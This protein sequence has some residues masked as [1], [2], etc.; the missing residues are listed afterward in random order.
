SHTRPGIVLFDELEK[1]SDE[2]ILAL[3]NVLDN[4]I[5]TVASGERTYSFRNSLIFMSSNL[6][7][8]ELQALADRGAVARAGPGQRLRH[9]V[10][11]AVTPRGDRRE[12]ATK[13][14]T[15]S[16]LKRFP[17][18]FV[19]RIDHIEAFDWIGAGD[20]PKLVAVELERLNRRL[21]KHGFTVELDPDT[22]DFIAERGFDPRF[23]ARGMR[24]AMRQH[25]EFPLAEYLLGL[26]PDSGTG[27]DV[28]GTRVLRAGRDGQR[29]TFRPA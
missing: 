9:A 2:V 18:E 19:N 17:P 5:L 11:R 10:A 16:L 14:V 20:M 22:T 27:K 26:R 23:G 4:G 13:I 21:A 24:R 28:N 8:R 6:G 7:A 3:L 29:L 15:T 1:A 25:L 12:A